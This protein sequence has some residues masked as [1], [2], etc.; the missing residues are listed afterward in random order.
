MILSLEH[1]A[2]SLAAQTLY[3]DTTLAISRGVL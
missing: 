1:P 2:L 3:R